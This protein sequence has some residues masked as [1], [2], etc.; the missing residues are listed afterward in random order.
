MELWT[1]HANIRGYADDTASSVSATTEDE[2]ITKLEEDADQIL[3][4]MASNY[5]VANAKKTGFLLISR[6]RSSSQQSIKIGTESVLESDA[7]RILGLTV[8]NRLTWKDHVYGQGELLSSLN[9]RIGA[10]KRLS[11]HVPSKYLA[12]I[13]QAIVVSKVRYGIG[14]YGAVRVHE[15]DPL[16]ES[17]KDLQVILN[18]AMRIAT[19]TRLSDR[20][21][22]EDLLD[23]T[24]F[25]S[26]NRMSA[27]D[28]LML[29]W[30]AVNQDGSPL[31]DTVIRVSQGDRDSSRS[32][33]RGDLRTI[34]KTTLGQENFPEPGIRLWNYA[35][36]E[37]REESIK[38]KA[39]KNV[40][41][42][43]KRFPL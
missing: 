33:T 4:Y 43:V 13:A 39:R 12:Q 25:Q 3:R 36:R 22:I 10:L 28:K 18:H 19:K 7:H 11:F 32:M 5:L 14:I 29:V 42:F 34:A 6:T 37:I 8:N 16:P 23:R 1:R 26:I 21:R 24:G 31:A 9:Q 38:R 35:D 15:T 30:Q 27:T 17:L 40:K 20:I 2:V 41:S